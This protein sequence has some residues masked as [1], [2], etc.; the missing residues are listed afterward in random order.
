MM[1][2]AFHDGWPRWARQLQPSR[3][4]ADTWKRLGS[5]AE[6]RR[7]FNQRAG[8]LAVAL[9]EKTE[10]ANAIT[11]SLGYLLSQTDARSLAG[12][13]EASVGNDLQYIRVNG[14]LVGGLAGLLLEAL[15]TFSR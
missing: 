1:T 5:D 7:S 15:R 14:A 2:A 8:D 3:W 9:W 12:R 13:I 11:S 4:A 6:F 10:A